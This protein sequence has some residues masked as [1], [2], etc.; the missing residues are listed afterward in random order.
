[1][2]WVCSLCLGMS[3]TCVVQALPHATGTTILHCTPGRCCYF[4][5]PF[6]SSKGL[7]EFRNRTVL[8]KPV[9]KDPCPTIFTFSSRVYEMCRCVAVGIKI[10]CLARA[11][12]QIRKELVNF[13]LH[14]RKSFRYRYCSRQSKGRWRP[15]ILLRHASRNHDSMFVRREQRGVVNDRRVGIAAPLWWSNSRRRRFFPL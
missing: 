6:P 2:S 14:Y 5:E 8:E 10:E 11:Q 4:P 9:A 1:V 7:L 13:N 12:R 15:W 3:P